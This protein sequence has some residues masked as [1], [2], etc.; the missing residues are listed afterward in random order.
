MDL[1]SLKLTSTYGGVLSLSEPDKYPVAT[2]LNYIGV[3]H[4]GTDL[5]GMFQGVG[6]WSEVSF[7]AVW[8]FLCFSR[9]AGHPYTEIMD[10]SCG[11]GMT[12]PY[13]DAP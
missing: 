5:G 3:S 12:R 13:T 2:V 4:Q 7:D 8:G 10:R 1:S 11:A 9:R 6:A